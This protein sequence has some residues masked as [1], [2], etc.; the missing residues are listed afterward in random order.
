[1]PDELEI[2]P[3]GRLSKRGSRQFLETPL[4]PGGTPI[5]KTVVEKI[6][7]SEPS[8]GDEPGTPA[9]RKRMADAVPDV[10]LANPDPTKGSRYKDG[11]GHQRASSN[12]SIPETVVTR[13]DDELAHGEVPGTAAAEKRKRDATPD[14]LEI[15]RDASGR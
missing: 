4:T 13:A 5:P 6:D 3:E 15:E 7:P 14:H 9:Y 11:S 1:M 8:Y 10:T 12:A 2:I